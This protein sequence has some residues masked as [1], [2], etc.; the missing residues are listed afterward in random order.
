MVLVHHQHGEQNVKHTAYQF[1]IWDNSPRIKH[2]KTAYVV[3][4]SQDK[5]VL[6]LHIQIM[7]RFTVEDKIKLQ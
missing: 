3:Y 7:W 2:M 5:P 1:R 4:D 6:P